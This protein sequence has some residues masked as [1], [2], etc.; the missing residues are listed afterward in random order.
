MAAN[1]DD[2]CL[3]E[4][5]YRSLHGALGGRALAGAASAPASARARALAAPAALAALL[6]AATP[7]LLAAA[8]L[9]PLVVSAGQRWYINLLALDG[10]LA[11]DGQLMLHKGSL[12][13]HMLVLHRLALDA[14]ALDA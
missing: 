13:L 8:A 9:L 10:M 3:R 14:L 5:I 11:F 7:L 2:P 1:C 4:T 6:P 12:A